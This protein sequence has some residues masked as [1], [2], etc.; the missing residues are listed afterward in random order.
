M[1]EGKIKNKQS[2]SKRGYLNFPI[3][4]IRNFLDDPK[5]IY[6]KI[7][8]CG[9]YNYAR[10][11][12]H[13]EDMEDKVE[14]TIQ[15]LGVKKVDDKKKI[16]EFAESVMNSNNKKAMTGIETALLNEYYLNYKSEFEKI[17][18]LAYLATVSIIGPSAYKK[19]TNELLFCRMAG[20]NSISDINKIP[21]I[22]KKYYTR[23]YID[24][25]KNEL[26]GKFNV[27]I[28][29]RNVRGFYVSYKLSYEVLVEKVEENRKSNQTKRKN[30]EKNEIINRVRGK[31]NKDPEPNP[32]F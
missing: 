32:D 30:A 11:L 16:I 14:Q 13:P 27:K 15:Y 7:L 20:Y 19:M 22:L 12:Y 6:T 5:L 24:K 4:L 17:V 21:S 10:T 28:Y 25:I 9:I 3:I 1:M 26:Q 2:K 31:Y 18:L 8:Y 23:K 29:G